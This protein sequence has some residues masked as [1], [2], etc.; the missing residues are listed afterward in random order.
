MMMYDDV[1]DD[2]SKPKADKDL[3]HSKPKAGDGSNHDALA[4]YPA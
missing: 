2:D 4:R 3:D 1:D